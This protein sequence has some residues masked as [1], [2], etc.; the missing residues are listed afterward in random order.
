MEA[1]KYWGFISYSRKDTATAKRLHK[2][3]ERYRIPR[4]LVGRQGGDETVPRRLLPIFL[5]RE[6]LAMCHDLSIGIQD[7]LKASRYLI[8]L[9]SPASATSR[10]VNEE[11]KFF[12]T[13]GREDR[14]LAVILDGEP[15]AA[16]NGLSGALECFPP[17]LR[18]RIGTDGQLTDIPAEPKAGDLRPKRDGW[19]RTILNAAA[20]MTGQRLDDFVRREATRVFR[21]RATAVAVV[22]V[23]LAAAFLYADYARTRIESFRNIVFRRGVPEG[24]FPL[25]KS[26]EYRREFHYVIESSRNKV[27]S[28]RRVNSAGILRDDPERHGASII[29]V[30]YDDDDAAGIKWRNHNG[31]VVLNEKYSAIRDSLQPG[32][33]MRHVDFKDNK[34]DWNQ[35]M[36]SDFGNLSQSGSSGSFGVDARSKVIASEVFYDVSGYQ[37]RIEYTAGNEAKYPNAA[38]AFG[39]I[40]QNDDRGLVLK[41][42]NI[43]KH[44]NKINDR[45]GVAGIRYDY[46]AG[47]DRIGRTYLSL[48]EENEPGTGPDSWSRES[49]S[50]SGDVETTVYAS[51]NGAEALACRGYSKAVRTFDK[52]GFVTKESWFTQGNQQ[53]RN[54]RCQHSISRLHDESGNVVRED[55]FKA[56]AKTGEVPAPDVSVEMKYGEHGNVTELSFLG[57]NGGPVADPTEGYWKVLKKYDSDGYET[58]QAYLGVDGQPAMNRFGCERVGASYRSGNMVGLSCMGAGPDGGLKLNRLGYAVARFTH[59]DWGA[60]RTISFFGEDGKTRK[61]HVEGWAEV[62]YEYDDKGLNTHEFY[63]DEKGAEG[64]V[65]VNNGNGYAHAIFSYDSDGMIA[66]KAYFG[67]ADTAVPTEIYVVG[68]ERRSQCERVGLKKDDILVRYGAND[69]ATMIQLKAMV[70]DPAPGDRVLQVRRGGDLLTFDVHPGRLGVVMDM[71]LA[72]TT[73]RTAENN[74]RF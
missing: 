27:Q 31:H 39:Q 56:A 67:Q 9:C 50:R 23:M 30:T 2:S 53:G 46:N 62:A 24:V 48:T 29:E 1:V 63:Y 18:F 36:R 57:P 6:E 41:I 20:G 74:C 59:T 19:R 16:K 66:D 61:R 22:T 49:V 13:I 35:S 34:S 8:V 47:G 70:K 32:L 37:V 68:C 42:W 58:E 40:F 11:I 65:L 17:A 25:D 3:I 28:V 60:V 21:R 69:L 33:Q 71:R 72:T 73:A 64:G 51:E 7:A 12:K 14:I 54:C 5:D 4:S 26:E 43:D 45:L 10:W 52:R 38:G 15:N 44:G 55:Y